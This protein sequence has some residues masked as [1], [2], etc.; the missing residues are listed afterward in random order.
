MSEEA[1]PTVLYWLMKHVLLGPIL[2]LFFQPKIIEGAE[3]IPKEGGAILASNHL[4][5]SDSFF[6]PL[7][8]SRR[9]DAHC[10]EATSSGPTT[11]VAAVS[12]QVVVDVVRLKLLLRLSMPLSSTE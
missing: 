3:N 7:K 4:A 12:R 8:L 1:L 11:A 9:V 10:G 2:R 6:L 5:V